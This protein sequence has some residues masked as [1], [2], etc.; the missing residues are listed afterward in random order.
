MKP[1]TKRLT[2]S[3]PCLQIPYKRSR[4]EVNDV[5]EF[6]SI[7]ERMCEWCFSGKKTECCCLCEQRSFEFTGKVV[8]GILRQFTGITV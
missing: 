1:S 5:T 6:T 2:A 4:L 3:P 7:L 8:P